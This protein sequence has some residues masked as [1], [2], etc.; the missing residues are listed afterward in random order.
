MNVIADICIIPLGVGVSVSREIAVCERIF[1]D[2][3]LSTRLH[4]YGTNV[5]GDWDRVFEAVKRCHEQLHAQGVPRISTN[6]RFGTRTDRD[7]TIDD[8]VR[9]VEQK[10]KSGR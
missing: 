2:A 1:A 6:I 9:S 8:K 3:G 4:A 10:L 5:E 7:Q